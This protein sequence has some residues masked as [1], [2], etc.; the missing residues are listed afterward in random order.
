[1]I[2]NLLIGISVPPVFVGV[3]RALLY[4][5]VM[6]A[7]AGLITVIPSLPWGVYAAAVPVIIGGLRSIE[8]SLD[9]HATPNQNNTG[10]DYGKAGQQLADKSGNA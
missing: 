9:Q 2:K 3:A 4:A 5:A 1:M 7:L 6:G 8:G 10:V